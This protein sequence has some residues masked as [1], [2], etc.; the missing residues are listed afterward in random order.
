MLAS[1]PVDTG[2]PDIDPHR[3][4]SHSTPYFA[5]FAGANHPARPPY[6]RA[7]VVAVYRASWKTYTHCRGEHAK[8]DLPP[9]SPDA[10]VLCAGPSAQLCQDLCNA[11][12][13]LPSKCPWRVHPPP[14]GTPYLMY[15]PTD[16]NCLTYIG[17]SIW[18]QS[19][20]TTSFIHDFRTVF[21]RLDYTSYV[22]GR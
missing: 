7:G 2:F 9:R 15:L 18:F 5:P 3:A 1:S 4:G 16:T 12:V 6:V 14:P 11:L 8:Q 13:G 21:P 17:T 19:I 22:N 20:T 10:S